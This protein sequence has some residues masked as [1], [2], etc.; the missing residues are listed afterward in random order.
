MM[1]GSAVRDVLRVG[2]LDRER[3]GPV[4]SQRRAIPNGEVD[5][6]WRPAARHPPDLM[7][8]ASAEW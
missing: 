3:R 8:M 7:Q 4:R 5:V 6:R 2:T 1:V